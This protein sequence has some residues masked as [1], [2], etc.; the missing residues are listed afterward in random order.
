VQLWEACY[1]RQTSVTTIFGYHFRSTI[2]ETKRKEV[3]MALIKLSKVNESG[4]NA[5]TVFINTDQIVAVTTGQSTTENLDVRWT[6]TVGQTNSRGSRGACEGIR[7][8][9]I[10]LIQKAKVAAISNYVSLEYNRP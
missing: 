2:P 6:A 9:A 8:V 4:E 1:I 5:G 10:H 3:D 7:V